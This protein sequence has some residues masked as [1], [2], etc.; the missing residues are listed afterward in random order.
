MR[1]PFSIPI[2]KGGN[3]R[4]INFK[5]KTSVPKGRNTWEPDT[6]SKVQAGLF[7]TVA[8]LAAASADAEYKL[9]D[10]VANAK[11]GKQP[12]FPIA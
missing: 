12:V 6:A 11:A 10:A 3:R 1:P 5:V 9:M 8:M 7:A 4:M 2:C